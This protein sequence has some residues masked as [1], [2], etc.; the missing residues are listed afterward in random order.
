[1]IALIFLKLFPE[2]VFLDVLIES[3]LVEE[4]LFS[5][6]TGKTAEKGPNF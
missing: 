2:A 4:E 5:R 6:Q 1:L 3:L